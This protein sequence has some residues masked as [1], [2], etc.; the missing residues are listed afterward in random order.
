VLADGIA[1]T[2]HLHG[3]SSGDEIQSGHVDGPHGSHGPERQGSQDVDSLLQAAT[4][5]AVTAET[6]L[7]SKVLGSQVSRMLWVMKMITP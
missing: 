5:A 1:L 3:M 2:D 6:D 7:L 4:A